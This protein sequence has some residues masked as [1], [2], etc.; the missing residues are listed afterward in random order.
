MDGWQDFSFF[1]FSFFS[2][3]FFFFSCVPGSVAYVFECDGA[4]GV[5]GRFIMLSG[6]FCG[7]THL[8]S[9]L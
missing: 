1:F 5:M 9:I 2:L 3:F 7:K 4:G 8:S 6:G